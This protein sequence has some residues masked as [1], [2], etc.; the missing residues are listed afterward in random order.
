MAVLSLLLV[1]LASIVDSATKLWR[2]NENRVDSYRE[3]RAA[4]NIISGD[5]QAAYF[6]R[7]AT[8]LTPK[9]FLLNSESGLPG[10][11]LPPSEAGNIMFV[12]A[13]P[14][15]S[16]DTAA[17]KDKSDLCSI[18]YFLAYDSPTLNSSHRSL[19]LYRYFRGS[20][21]TFLMIKSDT[22]IS[23]GN[24]KPIL[25]GPSGE[26][27][28]ARNIVSLKI[29]A[30]IVDPNGGLV[31]EYTAQPDPT[32]GTVTPPSFIDIELTALNNEAAKRLDSKSDW[33]NTSSVP[34]KTQARTFTTRVNLSNAKPQQ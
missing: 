34:Y 31:K 10:T 17:D 24:G 29:K 25:T 22:S 33:Q 27:V 32:T 21:D 3:A 16:Q 6:V 5:L 13:L 9:F 4:L 19:N 18:G 23:S 8:P 14:H 1:I 7:E 12:S 15:D 11:A 26:E 30:Y 28:L 20:D 2:Q